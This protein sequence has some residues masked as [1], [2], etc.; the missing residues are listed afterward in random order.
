M[1][2]IRKIINGRKIRHYI[3]H[4]LTLIMLI[5]AAWFIFSNSIFLIRNLNDAFGGEPIIKQETVQF[6][7]EGFQKLN[8]LTER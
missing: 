6:D 1:K 5:L 7:R 3:F 4:V 8:L 2:S